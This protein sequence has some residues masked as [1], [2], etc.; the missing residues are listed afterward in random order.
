[1][2]IQ[3][4]AGHLARGDVAS[5]ER[6]AQ[7]LL[8]RNEDPDALHLMAL[9]RIRQ[10]RV[11]EA[12]PFF[13]RSLAARPHHPHVRFNLGKALAL[14]KRDA[15]AAAALE[16]AIRLDPRLAAAWYELGE[17]Q[18]RRQQAKEAE[19]SF[20][21]VL[22]LDPEHLLA[23]LSLGVLLKDNGKPAAGEPLLAQGLARAEDPHLK[24]GF[25][26][27]LAQCQYALGKKENALENFNLVRQLEP[28]R[29]SVE[30]NL[31]DLFEEMGRFEEAEAR[32]AALLRREPENEDAHQAYN[33]LMHRLGRDADFLSSYARAPATPA[34]LASKA[35]FLF[36]T[37]RFAE[38][39][40]VYARV[41]QDDPGNLA[42]AIGAAS[43]LNQA[44][45][46]G[47]A[48][49][50]LEQVR[51]HHPES[52]VVF[53]SLSA[54]ALQM[55][56]PKLAAAFAEQSL[57]LAPVDHA[58]LA[59]LGSAWRMMGDERDEMLNGYEDLIGI[60]DLEVPQG[61]SSMAEFN[62]ALSNALDAMHRTS[63]EPI[64]QSLRG[65]SQT[66]GNI[67]NDGIELV[68]RLKARINEAMR[69]Y[70]GSIR[71]DARHPFRGRA[72][73]S[74]RFTGSWS[75]RLKDC[76]Y[77][78]NHIHPEGWI[79]SC[80]YVAVPEAVKNDET[81]EGWIKFGE[82]SVE[83]G[84]GFRRA[85]QPQPGRLVLFPSYMWHGTIPFHDKAVRTTIAFDAVPVTP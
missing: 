15:E 52:P 44:G 3:D 9:T 67:F 7:T 54:T 66:R 53:H 63:R 59:F 42:A 16:Q 13:S 49:A 32:L 33:D 18:L 78:I 43:C 30:I 24:A 19:A 39:F 28:S 61:F 82:P 50:R 40:D 74:Y 70:I 36:K 21:Q 51:N 69:A 11:E 76:G 72:T 37:G 26:Y 55:R 25:A 34:L 60:L 77:H 75:S 2:T 20:R 41:V 45:R 84:L 58:G 81:K 31:T 35:A 8:A 29:S 83:A 12:L 14:L 71:P 80:Y 56:D 4:G 47:E 48:M 46:H 5:A 1:M 22:A 73:A 27:N 62:G 38:A 57:R 64:A 23:K 17:V 6:V 68:E 85:I 10:N 65:G 79:S